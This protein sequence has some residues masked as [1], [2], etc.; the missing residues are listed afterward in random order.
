MQEQLKDST[1]KLGDPLDPE[2][3]LRILLIGYLYGISRERPEELHRILLELEPLD[4]V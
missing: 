3:L 1:A 4:R 2:L